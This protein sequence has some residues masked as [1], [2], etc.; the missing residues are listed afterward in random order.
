[1][2]VL[3]RLSL[4]LALE[5]GALVALG[6]GYAV[7]GLDEAG[8]RAPAQLAAAASVVAGAVL[9]LLARAV[10]RARSWSRGPSITLNILPFPVSA[11]MVR[12]GAWWLAVPVVLLAGTVLYL[13][14]TQ[15]LREVF[16]ERS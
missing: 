6:I 5:G 8:D 12:G 7:A 2:P 1:M 9:L 3:R 16:Q 10:D 13:F 15:E 11:E 4:L 14:A